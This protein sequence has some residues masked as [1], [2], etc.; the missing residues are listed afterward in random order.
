MLGWTQYGGYKLFNA[1]NAGE[2][3]PEK[4]REAAIKSA[5]NVIKVTI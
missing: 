1:V 2:M 4:A 5:R 3:S